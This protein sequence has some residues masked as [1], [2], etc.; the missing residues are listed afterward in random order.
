MTAATSCAATT[1]G[2]GAALRSTSLS[3]AVVS[4]VFTSS[5]DVVDRDKTDVTDI[6]A[7][8]SRAAGPAFD[9][10]SDADS[11]AGFDVGLGS[12]G[13]PP[14]SPTGSPSAGTDSSGSDTT[15]SGTMFSP[16]SVTSA[17]SDA[18]DESCSDN[19]SSPVG[20]V[21]TSS[22]SSVSLSVPS[23]TSAPP[24]LRTTTR[25]PLGDNDESGDSTDEDCSSDVDGEPDSSEESDDAL[26][27][28]FEASDADGSATATHGVLVTAVPIPSATAST[29]SRPMAF[30]PPD[31]PPVASM[32][33]VI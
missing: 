29:P 10:G 32:F 18:V 30:A 24:E 12:V 20:V 2:A 7:G 4:A 26:D 13:G 11:G 8:C 17:S 16:G 28:E 31:A 33:E 27:E 22:V 23:D 3:G 25:G 6:D 19:D 15:F 21:S 14:D 5:P 9:T 1:F